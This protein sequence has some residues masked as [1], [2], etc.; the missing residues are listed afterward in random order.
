M[1]LLCYAASQRADTV[2]PFFKPHKD[3]EVLLVHPAESC[4]SQLK[5]GQWQHS[6]ALI[7]RYLCL[8]T[9]P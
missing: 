1:V 7:S 8:C 6:L 4:K 5:G 3:S 9:G 2:R